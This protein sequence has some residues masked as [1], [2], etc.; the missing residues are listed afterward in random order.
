MEN[1]RIENTFNSIK[2]NHRK[3]LIAH[4]TAGYPNLQSLIPIMQSL[5][6]GGADILQIGIPFLDPVGDAPI[7]QKASQKAIENHFTIGDFFRTLTNIRQEIQSPIVLKAYY[8]SIFGY[9]EDKFIDE[10]SASGTD[11]VTVPDLPLEESSSLR[12]KLHTHGIPLIYT[13]VPASTER[14]NAIAQVSQGFIYLLPEY[15]PD[16]KTFIDGI[17][18]FARKVRDITQLPLCLG[19]ELSDHESFKTVSSGA[20]IDGLLIG[21]ILMKKICSAVEKGAFTSITEQ[22]EQA[23]KGFYS[24]QAIR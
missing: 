14:M 21:D 12:E 15:N 9:G 23:V 17:N 6:A 20:Q 8:T 18:N 19:M 3:A 16:E 22:L 7:V 2:Q 4:I 10:C 5:Q 11:A 13:M 1:S 24:L